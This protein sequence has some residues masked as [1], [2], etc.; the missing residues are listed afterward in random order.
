MSRAVSIRA[1]IERLEIECREYEA[2]VSK[3]H[4]ARLVAFAERLSRAR[5]RAGIS[6]GSGHA[7]ETG[8]M[9]IADRLDRARK[10]LREK[11]EAE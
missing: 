10:L 6:G 9:N 4:E 11:R 2:P 8:P 3:L 5:K 7:S 1:R